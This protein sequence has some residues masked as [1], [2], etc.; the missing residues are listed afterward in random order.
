MR[1]DS[2]PQEAA[3]C[4]ARAML[5]RRNV[6]GMKARG[7]ICAICR[8]HYGLF[9]DVKSGAHVC[10]ACDKA[11]QKPAR[12]LVAAYRGPVRLLEVVVK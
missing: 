2:V 3:S 5:A 1:K 6:E 8:E 9:V 10:R 11:L 4:E 12:R 7:V